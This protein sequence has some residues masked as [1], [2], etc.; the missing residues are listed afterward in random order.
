MTFIRGGVVTEAESAKGLKSDSESSGVVASLLAR[1]EEM[2]GL[3]A[4]DSEVETGKRPFFLLLLP[5]P[6]V[7]RVGLP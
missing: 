1:G 5:L 3:V 6:T 2:I 4:E 7:R